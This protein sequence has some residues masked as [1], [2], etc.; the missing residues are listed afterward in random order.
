M[1]LVGIEG[2][3]SYG[4]GLARHISAAGVLVVEVDRSDRQDRRRQGKSDPLD[5]V[6]AARA[7]QPDRACG[8]REAPDLLHATGGNM[9]T[10]IYLRRVTVPTGAHASARVRGRCGTSRRAFTGSLPSP[11]EMSEPMPNAA[12]APAVPQGPDSAD[13]SR[14]RRPLLGRAVPTQ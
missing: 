8:K 5:A 13:R 14:T 3:G 4:A 11:G 2:T 6:S 9:S 1:R 10:R 7:A 12:T